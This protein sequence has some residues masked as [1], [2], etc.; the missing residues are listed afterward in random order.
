MDLRTKKTIAREF[1]ILIISVTIGLLGFVGIYIRTYLK[2]D[3]YR[4]LNESISKKSRIKDSLFLPYQE[5]LGI[6]NWFFGRYWDKA[7]KADKEDTSDNTSKKLWQFLRPLAEKDS[8]KYKWE[9]TWNKTVISFLKESG[10]PT[11][12]S[13]KSF[14]LLNTIS[15]ADSLNY[16]QSKIV[17]S[18]IDNLES[19]KRAIRSSLYSSKQEAEFGFKFFFISAAVLFGFRYFYYGIRWSVKTLK[20]KE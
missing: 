1:L 2:N 4:L 18:E 5:K 14:I 11:S 8:I 7:D 13:F 20:Q 17:K 12:D 19:E 16:A 6:Q 10:F 3:E 9:K 15:I